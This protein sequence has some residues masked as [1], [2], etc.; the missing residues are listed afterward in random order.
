MG[1]LPD[2]PYFFSVGEAKMLQC[3]CA[4]ITHIH[5]VSFYGLVQERE[6]ASCHQLNMYF[7]L[8]QVL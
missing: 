8:Q 6:T 4:H 5:D 3:K 7:G 2:E 1:I